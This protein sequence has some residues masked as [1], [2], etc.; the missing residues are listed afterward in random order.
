MEGLTPRQEEVLDLVLESLERRG[1]P[2]SIR[3]ICD[4]LGLSSTR[5][6]L[7]H[8]EALEKK[9]FITRASGARAIQVRDALR[10]AAAYLPLVGEVPA[11]P[12]RHASEEVEEWVPVPARWGGGGRFLLRVRGDSMSGDGIRDGDLVVVDP[13]PSARNGEVV[14][15]L[16][17]GEAT[18]KRLRR[19]GGAVELEASNPAYATLRVEKGE[20]EVRLAGRVVSLLR[21]RV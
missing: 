6:A 11:G 7:R 10:G 16:V 18:V 9:G 4:A 19:R 5:G 1:Y 8:L 17:D 3:E 13:S 12:L 20:A 15:A 2:P 21:D 14:V